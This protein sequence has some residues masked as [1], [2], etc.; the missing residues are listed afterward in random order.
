MY[1]RSSTTNKMSGN[2]DRA[3]DMA[4]WSGPVDKAESVGVQERRGITEHAVIAT[5]TTVLKRGT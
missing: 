1:F 3:R 2:V 5:N 4:V